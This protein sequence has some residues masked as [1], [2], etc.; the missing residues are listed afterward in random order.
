MISLENFKNRSNIHFSWLNWEKHS[1]IRKMS[2]VHDQYLLLWCYKR[3]GGVDQSWVKE[4]TALKVHVFSSLMQR[5]G[6][7]KYEIR[8]FFF[9]S[10]GLFSPLEVCT[11]WLNR[12][13][14]RAKT[15]SSKPKVC[16]ASFVRLKNT[17]LSPKDKVNY[18]FLKV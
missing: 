8:L 6:E 18:W 14:L 7:S 10:S 11:I 16:L 1:L 15:H 2:L 12:H 9:S 4:W 3:R 13:S 17:L 5:E